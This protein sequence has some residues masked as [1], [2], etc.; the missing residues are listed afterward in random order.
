M[1]PSL[2]H[3]M[4]EAAST[5]QPAPRE[6]NEFRRTLEILLPAV[7]ILLLQS[8]SL[9]ALA[10]A[11]ID[12][13]AFLC[14][15]LA[16]VLFAFAWAYAF[17]RGGQ[18]NRFAVLLA[19]VA[20]ALG[21]VG[22]I[23]LIVIVP[24]QVFLRRSSTPFADWYQLL[25]PDE[26]EDSGDTLYR[27]IASGRAELQAA[28]S[29]DNFIDVMRA[30][31][32]EQKRAVITI[33][34]RQFR[35]EFAPTLKLALQDPNPAIRV[36]AATASAEIENDFLDASIALGE[37]VQAAPWDFDAHLALAR[38]YDAYAFCGLLDPQRERDM[39]GR[40]LAAYQTAQKLRPDHQATRTAISRLLVRE[41][42]FAEAVDWLGERLDS[43]KVNR[44]LVAWYVECLFHLRR[45]A[46][47][48]GV[49][50]RFGDLLLGNP[51]EPDSVTH[52][53]RLWQQQ[54]EQR[55]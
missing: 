28:S 6:R 24:L 30:G 52:A 26:V 31:S 22:T 1:I 23:G 47:L 45:Y 48:H 15:H 40:A 10:V 46:D 41:R 39:R 8:A 55:P 29:I 3:Q 33:L 37:A 27:Q 50:A 35:P 53:V 13:R 18:M 34:V 2:P 14:F 44:A 20:G 32:I 38:H 9:W 42:R 4:L 7:V 11:L 16:A 17:R 51:D 25:F 54:S 43:G 36:Q 19:V 12:L 21:I 49:I 5:G